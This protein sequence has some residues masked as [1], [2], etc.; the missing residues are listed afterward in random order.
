[1]TGLIRCYQPPK[2]HKNTNEGATSRR[3]LFVGTTR[4]AIGTLRDARIV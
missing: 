2:G 4:A 3:W 1:M